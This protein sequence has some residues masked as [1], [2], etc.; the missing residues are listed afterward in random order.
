MGTCHGLL[1]IRIVWNVSFALLNP[2]TGMLKKVYV[3]WPHFYSESAIYGFGYDPYK[4]DYKVVKI[5]SKELESKFDEVKVYSISR[6]AYKI[7]NGDIVKNIVHIN[8]D[9]QVFLDG[10]IYWL[11]SFEQDRGDSILGFDMNKEVFDLIKLPHCITRK[12]RTII[13][14]EL[15]GSL[16]V[17]YFDFGCQLE[18]WSMKKCGLSRSW[19]RQFTTTLFDMGS[20]IGFGRDGRV[21]LRHTES[22]NS[23]FSSFVWFDLRSN[24]VIDILHEDNS[25]QCYGSKVL[26]GYVERLAPIVTK[27]YS[28]I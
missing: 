3:D 4:N 28:N 18:I 16:S 20:P 14:G 23:N 2:P 25:K 13:L 6:N 10:C 24:H 11:C 22:G 9:G 21:L 19:N 15:W 7:V 17:L 5:Y 8:R 27:N 26:F 1:L 12:I